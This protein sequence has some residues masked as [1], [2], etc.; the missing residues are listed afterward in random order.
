MIQHIKYTYEAATN[1]M[2]HPYYDAVWSDF[3]T[4]QHNSIQWEKKDSMQF[5][6]VDSL[7]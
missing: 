4:I 2:I 1:V 7:L 6:M 3:D 5:N